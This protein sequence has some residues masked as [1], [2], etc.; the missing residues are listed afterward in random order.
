M[1]VINLTSPATLAE[2]EPA[3]ADD[4]SLAFREVEGLFQSNVHD[5]NFSKGPALRGE[6]F[7]GNSFSEVFSRKT[8]SEHWSVLPG[9]SGF[10]YDIP[11]GALRFRLRHPAEVL[12]FFSATIFRLNKYDGFLGESGPEGSVLAKHSWIFNGIWEGED[13]EPGTEYIQA[14]TMVRS[15]ATSAKGATSRGVFLPW[16]IK[17]LKVDIGSSAT[18]TNEVLVP[19]DLGDIRMVSPTGLLGNANPSEVGL[20]QAGWHNIRHTAQWDENT[21]LTATG[22][23]TNKGGFGYDLNHKDTAHTMVFGN[24][25]LVVVANYGRRSDDRI[26]YADP[27]AD[28]FKKVIGD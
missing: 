23:M 10:A 26:V 2:G 9:R 28:P 19:K 17:P 11:G 15:K 21:N 16:S 27:R 7:R 4:V 24:T 18:P 25:E 13:D 22:N 1:T 20:L 14:R 5:E 6:S 3:I 12:V 8:T